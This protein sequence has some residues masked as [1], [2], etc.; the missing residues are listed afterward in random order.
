MDVFDEAAIRLTR[1]RTMDA[2]KLL[3][4][5]FWGDPFSEYLFPDVSERTVLEEKFY[6]LNIQHAMIGG[7]VY[8][9]SSFKGVA[10]WRFFGDEKSKKVEAVVDPRKG[11]A[12]AMGDGPFQRLMKANGAL[13][14]SHKRIMPVPH[15]Y[16]LFLG[17]EPGQQGK[18]Y[19]GILIDPILR[20]ADE[21]GLP[22]YLE[23]MKEVNLLF[24]DKHGFKIV[25]AKQLPDDGPF[26]WFL[27]RKPV[28][29]SPVFLPAA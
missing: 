17:V 6:L 12:K 2:A 3:G 25:Q 22:C 14:E 20:Y 9:T 27:L 15:C 4:R 11:L 8:T 10:A 1:P 24:Y 26:T 7:E 19:G 23:T 13:N 29:P 16:L 28:K 5:A 18:G 21:K